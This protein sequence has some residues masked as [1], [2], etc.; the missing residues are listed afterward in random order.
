MSERDFDR[1]FVLTGDKGAGWVE[2]LMA[3]VHAALSFI[4]VEATLLHAKSLVAAIEGKPDRSFYLIDVNHFYCSPVSIPKFSIMV[5]DP[6]TRVAD[7]ATGHPAAEMLGW[8]DATHPGAA[9]AIGLPFSSIFLPH[10]GPDPVDQ[11][12]S[13]ADRPIDV[14]FSGQLEEPVDRPHLL[15]NLDVPESLAHILFDAA[16]ICQSGY[17]PPIS[18]FLKSCAHHGVEVKSAFDRQVFCRLVSTVQ[19]IA[20]VN[21]RNAILAA[22]PDIRIV[23]AS[24][25]LPKHLRGRSNL[26]HLGYVDDFAEIRRLMSLSKI[27]LNTTSKYPH[28]A[29]E[30]IWFGMAEG[31]ALL[32][33]RSNYVER[34]F[35]HEAGILYLPRGA[36]GK[37]DLDWLKGLVERRTAIGK[38]TEAA[39]AIYQRKHT[40]K[41]RIW[42]IQDAMK[43][44]A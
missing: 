2:A 8:V 14:F 9:A 1:A 35:A 24:R 15:T 31:A 32:T 29:H 17:E 18:V 36:V 25:Y 6:C 44:A 28:G 37:G 10:A 22:L 34:D 27:V 40:W 20:E 39:R 42:T 43:A 16:A 19:R 21:R 11:P 4:G 7:V 33:D 12:V 23:V 38:I 3:E 13:I 30:R 5:D 26:A 41:Q